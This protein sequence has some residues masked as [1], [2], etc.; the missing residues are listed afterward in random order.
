MKIT[1]ENEKKNIIYINQKKMDLEGRHRLAV[2]LPPCGDCADG[3]GRRR[4][5]RIGLGRPRTSQNNP[6]RGEQWARDVV[7]R[8]GE[9]C[10]LSWPPAGQVLSS[11]L[12]LRLLV[13]ER[14]DALLGTDRVAIAGHNFRVKLWQVPG[15]IVTGPGWRSGE[16]RGEFVR[17]RWSSCEVVPGPG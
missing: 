11:S 8:E 17:K 14:T 7:R 9:G 5:S 13:I 3:S 6:G 10:V 4:G 1:Y 16:I 15:W 12:L 2:E